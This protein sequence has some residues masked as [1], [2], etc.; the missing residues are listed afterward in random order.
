MDIPSNS[1]SSG[2]CGNAKDLEQ[3]I[4]LSWISQSDSSLKDNFT[5]Y[6][7]KNETEKHY[8]LDRLEISLV[9]KEF[10][11]N[12][13]SMNKHF[14]HELIYPL[15]FCSFLKKTFIPSDETII[16]EHKAVQFGIGLSNSYRC[17]KEQTLNLTLRGT[18]ETVGHLKIS[19]L[20]FQAFRSDNTTV[21]ALGR[22]QCNLILSNY[23]QYN[24]YWYC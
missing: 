14:L 9:P 22:C 20:Q 15:I 8:S 3:N 16:L 4:M 21:F 6:F 5:L 17:F 19:G 12:E 23:Y 18:N 10:L 24:I 2:K 13:S 1:N 11:N 7:V